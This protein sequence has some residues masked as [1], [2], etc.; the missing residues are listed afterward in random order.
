MYSNGQGVVPSNFLSFALTPLHMLRLSASFALL[1]IMH[2]CT[3]PLARFKVSTSG[4]TIPHLCSLIA[5]MSSS[6]SLVCFAFAPSACSCSQSIFVKQ[7]STTS[8]RCI[9]RPW[10]FFVR[11]V[12]AAALRL[13]LNAKSCGLENTSVDT[14][15]WLIR[16]IPLRSTSQST[17][18][19]PSNCWYCSVTTSA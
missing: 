11:L 4:H 16:L 9:F 17:E 14:K 5:I 3:M 1:L 15:C 19:E 7:C 18:H 8:L 12:E 10:P 2:A 6:G 13:T